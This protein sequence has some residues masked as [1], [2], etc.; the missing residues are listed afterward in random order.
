MKNVLS[1]NMPHTFNTA[2]TL[3]S[4]S[5][6]FYIHKS[7]VNRTLERPVA[8]THAEAPIRGGA[9]RPTSHVSSRPLLSPWQ[10]WP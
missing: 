2:H 3:I 6:H 5:Y 4:G 10:A 9:R 8:L 1:I 7:Q